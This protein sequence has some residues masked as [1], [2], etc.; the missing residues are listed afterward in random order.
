MPF[1]IARR[2][3][4][5]AASCAAKGVL[6]REPLKPRAPALAQ[7]TVLPATS[8]T[9]T[10]VLLNVERMC[11]TP[12]GMFLRWTRLAPRF[13]PAG[14]ADAVAMVGLESLYLKNH[15]RRA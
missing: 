11:A 8:V 12:V 1:S 13:L 15:L 5:S 3:A 7:D 6:L 14:G 9:V 2:A 4:S 10:M